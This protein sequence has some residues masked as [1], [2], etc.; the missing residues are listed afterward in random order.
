[1]DLPQMRRNLATW[2]VS[3]EQLPA[4]A[5]FLHD[6]LPNEPFDP[7]FLGQRLKTTYF[8]TARFD[9]RAARRRGRRYL[10]LRLRCYEAPGRE[11]LYA[12]SAKTESEKWRREVPTEVAE[13]ILAGE[14]AP[15]PLLPAHL[16]GR[17]QEFAGEEP[18]TGVVTVCCVR[19]AV[20][21]PADRYT[22]DVG[23]VTDTGKSLPAAVLEHKSLD[24]DSTPPAALLG[25]K[26]RPAKLSKFLWATE[27]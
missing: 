17:L 13:A 11:E 25:L 18:V 20:E 4:A 12:L 23:M 3:T 7:H 9:L 14:L 16:L 2:W 1:M 19:Y 27:V 22:L 24:P 26:L 5:H 10:T 8:D 21:D 6:V 15:G